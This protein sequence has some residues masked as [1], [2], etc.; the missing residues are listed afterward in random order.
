MLIFI[1]DCFYRFRTGNIKS[2]GKSNLIKF[3][4]VADFRKKRSLNYLL[5]LKIILVNPVN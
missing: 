3:G 1:I 4:L 2:I 5:E